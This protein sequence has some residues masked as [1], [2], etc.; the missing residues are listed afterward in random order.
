VDRRRAG[1]APCLVPITRDQT[2]G[3]VFRRSTYRLDV[4]V[5]GDGH[6]RGGPIDCP[7]TC[8]AT[9]DSGTAVTLRAEDGGFGGWSGACA[10]SNPGSTCALTVDGDTTVG[11]IFAP[12]EANPL[13]VTIL[14]EG[15]GPGGHVASAPAQISCPPTCSGGFTGNVILTATPDPGWT[16]I[17]WGGSCAGSNPTCTVGLAGGPQGV[18]ALFRVNEFT[19]TLNVTGGPNVWS[20]DG[21]LNCNDTCS[22]TYGNEA[23]VV[24]HSPNVMTPVVA[25][26][27]G[28]VGTTCTVV[29]DQDRTI[30]ITFTP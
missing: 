11:A 1:T 2:V 23:V 3:A 30:N 16:F 19:L 21:R 25:W 29:M 20:E 12:P 4:S 14:D 5:S 17:R 28:C 7:G 18:T 15:N 26:G 8:S 22:A 6:V 10:G 13:S 24:L 9:V 27:N